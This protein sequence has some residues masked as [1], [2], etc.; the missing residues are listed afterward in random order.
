MGEFLVREGL[1]SE[2]DLYEALSLQQRIP[3]EHVNPNEVKTNVAR[4]LPVALA[5]KWQVLPYKVAKGNIF[6]ASPALPTEEMQSELKTHVS[7]EIRFHLV[8]PSNFERLREKFLDAEST[9]G[10]KK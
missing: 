10:D 4:S 9:T 5:A 3:L 8:T 2:S 6:L 7:L 1:L